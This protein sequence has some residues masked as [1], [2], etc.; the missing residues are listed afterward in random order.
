MYLVLAY[1]LCMR[2]LKKSVHI[3]KMSLNIYT[4]MDLIGF[5]FCHT[6]PEERKITFIIFLVLWWGEINESI[7][8]Y[9]HCLVTIN[10]WCRQKANIIVQ[11]SK[12]MYSFP[13]TQI[14]IL[15]LLTANSSFYQIYQEIFQYMSNMSSFFFSYGNF[16]KKIK[17]VVLLFPSATFLGN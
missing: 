17:S 11:K 5:C 16:K 10:T 7:L 8:I 9:L 13:L 1:S 15:N 3:L 2:I 4:S 12:E 14:K 6:D